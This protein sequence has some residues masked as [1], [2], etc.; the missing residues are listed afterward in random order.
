VTVQWTSHWPE[1]EAPPAVVAGG[2]GQGVT[3]ALVDRLEPVAEHDRM[4]VP[5]LCAVGILSLLACSQHRA[6]TDELVA[7]LTSKG[8]HVEK[9]DDLSLRSEWV[10]AELGVSLVLDYEEN[11]RAVRFTSADLARGHCQEEQGGVPFGTWCL[12][13]LSRSTRQETWQKVA[14][15]RTL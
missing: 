14:L 6:S 13:P 7:A 15:L 4:K 3:V 11:Y 12:E 2:P 5:A 9:K 8:V 1:F 10:G